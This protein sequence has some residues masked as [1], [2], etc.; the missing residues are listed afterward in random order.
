[1][2]SAMSNPPCRMHKRSSRRLDQW[3]SSPVGAIQTTESTQPP[4]KIRIES[5]KPF[6]E[7]VSCVFI[8]NEVKL[9]V[10]FEGIEDRTRQPGRGEAARVDVGSP[11]QGFEG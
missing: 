5:C 7:K 2:T 11:V 9:V 4:S 6:L 10:R 1:M 8:E 3:V